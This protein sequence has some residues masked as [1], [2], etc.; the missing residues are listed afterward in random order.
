MGENTKI[1]LIYDLVKEIDKK[2][3]Q[4][5]ERLAKLEVNV[6]INTKDLT[7]HKEGVITARKIIA[8][9]DL[10]RTVKFQREV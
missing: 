10:N 9:N 7:E 8:Q 3:D 1:D 6:E 2:Q 4:Q 5:S